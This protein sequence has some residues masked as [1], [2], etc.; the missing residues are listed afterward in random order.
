M[1]RQVQAPDRAALVQFAV[2][3]NLVKLS[4]PEHAP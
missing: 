4:Q 2:K 1:R 3:H